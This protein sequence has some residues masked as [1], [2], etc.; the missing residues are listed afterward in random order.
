MYKHVCICDR[1]KKED[2]L[3]QDYILLDKNTKSVSVYELPNGWEEFGVF[4]KY[5]LC[6]NCSAT[7]KCG[8]GSY[9]YEFITSYSDNKE[10][11]Q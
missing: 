1:C 3:R 8:I 11:H 4:P 6:P 9:T 10:K 2:D 5:T 7:L